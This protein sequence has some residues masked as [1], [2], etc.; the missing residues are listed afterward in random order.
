VS[1]DTADSGVPGAL[2]YNS[3]AS[4]TSFPYESFTPTESAF[5]IDGTPVATPEPSSL[6]LLGAGLLGLVV[7]GRKRFAADA[8]AQS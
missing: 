2:Y 3:S 6:L 1:W 4:T 5:E 8:L 7:I